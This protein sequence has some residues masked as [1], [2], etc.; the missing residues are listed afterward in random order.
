MNQIL[1][2]LVRN[3]WQH[4]QKKDG[5]IQIVTRPGYMGDAVICELA[6][7]GP[8]IPAELRPQIFEP[9]FTTRPGGTG[10][11]LYI[12]RELADAN[13]RAVFGDYISVY[14]IQRAVADGATVPIYYESR[15][16]KLELKAS[17]RPRID[18]EFEEATEGEE[19][20][21]KPSLTEPFCALA[22]PESSAVTAASRNRTERGAFMVIKFFRRAAF[23]LCTD[24]SSGMWPDPGRFLRSPRVILTCAGGSFRRVEAGA[25]QGFP[26]VGGQVSYYL[27][28]PTRKGQFT[29]A[30]G[31][32]LAH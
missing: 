22:Q 16:A 31:V 2:N 8:G 30:L 25:R 6:D 3:A 17:E 7:D 19:V 1:W 18:P 26:R 20:E 23:R 10:L 15:L 14:D 27:D 24:K 9:F 32:S 11:G 28:D 21:R 29:A 13:T 12:A 5:S 4:C